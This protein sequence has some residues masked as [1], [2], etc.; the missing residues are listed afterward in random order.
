MSWLPQPPWP[1]TRPDR[2]STVVTKKRESSSSLLTAGWRSQETV[3][4]GMSLWYSCCVVHKLVTS[5]LQPL[6]TGVW[7]R[8]HLKS[9][10]L[11]EQKKRIWAPNCFFPLLTSSLCSFASAEI[12]GLTLISCTCVLLTFPFLCFCF[13][14]WIR[15][16]TRSDLFSLLRVLV[17]TLACLTTCLF[18]LWFINHCTEAALPAASASGSRSFHSVSAAHPGIFFFFS[19]VIAPDSTTPN[20]CDVIDENNLHIHATLGWKCGATAPPWLKE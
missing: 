20:N 5:E 15:S 13:A 6:Q 10:C 12:V 8:P 7:H 3:R 19:G 2:R 1:L 9:M 16:S 17:L 11:T 14:L 4:P 18:S